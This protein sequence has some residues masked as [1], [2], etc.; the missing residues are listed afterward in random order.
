MDSYNG[1]TLLRAVIDY[2]ADSLLRVLPKGYES[3]ANDYLGPLPDNSYLA[4]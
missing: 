2:E 3:N 1:W 4:W